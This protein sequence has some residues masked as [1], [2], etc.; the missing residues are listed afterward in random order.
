MADSPT[1]EQADCFETTNCRTLDEFWS[2]VSPIAADL[3]QPTANFVYRGQG[4]STW[5]LVPNIFRREVIDKYKRGPS[6]SLTNYPGQVF[7][8]WMLLN[9]FVKHCDAKGLAIPGDSMDFRAYFD[10]DNLGALHGKHTV[11]WPQ[12]RMWPLM[13]LAQHHGIPTRLLDWSGNP[14]AA[15]YFAAASV[16]SAAVKN[17]LPAENERLAVF[18][19]DLN[20]INLVDGLAHVRV[21][22]STSPNLS[23]QSGSFVLVNNAGS[24]NDEFQIGVSLESKLKTPSIKVLKKVTLPATLA[25]DLLLRCH[26]FGISAAS[27]FPGYDGAAQAALEEGLAFNMFRQ[28]QS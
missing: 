2:C 1:K 9:A 11:S 8:E 25:A 4:D 17:G 18:C 6:E 20:Q 24:R 16:V 23:A 22:G 7:F 3:E 26:K 12:E 28:L 13:A 27:I 15:C 14:Y 10:L 19:L 21:P 5:H